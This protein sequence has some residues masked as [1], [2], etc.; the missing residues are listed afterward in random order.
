MLC[1]V[2]MPL[3]SFLSSF[4]SKIELLKPSKVKIRLGKNQIGAGAKSAPN[5]DD[6]VT[7]ELKMDLESWR[8][9]TLFCLLTSPQSF[10]ITFY[11]LAYQLCGLLLN[12]DWLVDW[13][14]CPNI[15]A[16][17]CNVQMG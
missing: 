16:A 7:L 10:I 1:C 11:S 9:G 15:P 17:N 6:S 3:L 8:E 5:S 4:L 13:D 14:E 12:F 2:K